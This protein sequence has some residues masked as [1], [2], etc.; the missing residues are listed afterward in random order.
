MMKQSNTSTFVSEECTGVSA[1]WCHNCGPCNCPCFIHSLANCFECDSQDQYSLNSKYCSLHA[2][3]SKHSEKG[4][5]GF[6]VFD[7]NEKARYAGFK[8]VEDFLK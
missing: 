7:L 1:R 8:S 4:D 5:K 3:D 6:R 2:S